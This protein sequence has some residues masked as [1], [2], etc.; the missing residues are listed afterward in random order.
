[1][2]FTNWR[3]TIGRKFL[4]QNAEYVIKSVFNLPNGEW[5]IY[6]DNNGKSDIVNA[7]EIDLVEEP[8]EK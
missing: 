2:S 1:M 8:K 4:Y 3:L 6:F 5:L 7:H